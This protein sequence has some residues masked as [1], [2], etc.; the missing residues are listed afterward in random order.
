MDLEKQAGSSIIGALLR[1]QES[2]LEK[3]QSLLRDYRG[4]YVCIYQDEV[5]ASDESLMKTCKIAESQVKNLP[6]YIDLVEP[7]SFNLIRHPPIIFMDA[8][9]DVK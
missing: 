2:F 4:K 3:E 8:H 6:L 9:C 5:I 7:E 1:E